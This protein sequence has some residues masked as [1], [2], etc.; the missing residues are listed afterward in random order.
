MFNILCIDHL[1][2]RTNNIDKLLD[3]YCDVL[4]CKIEKKVNSGF[5]QLRAGMGESVYLK[6][7]AGNEIELK[8]SV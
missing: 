5:I 3:F 8:A 4:S 2:I 6:D 1:V 7:P